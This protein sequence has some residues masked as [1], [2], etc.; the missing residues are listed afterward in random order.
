M[1][2]PRLRKV[3][4]SDLSDPGCMSIVMAMI[5]ASLYHDIADHALAA[6]LATGKLEAF[7]IID[8]EGR[9]AGL[10]SAQQGYVNETKVFYIA[11][12]TMANMSLE[13]WKNLR[14]S[15]QFFARQRG[16]AEIAFDTT[17]DN[18]RMM[19]IGR[20]LADEECVGFIKDTDKAVYFKGGV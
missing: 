10:I 19:E 9:Q 13:G 17:P 16:C 6:M 11:T 14:S 3:T 8:D 15:L 2:N 1:D 7:W 20:M 12:A 5:R 4:A 18:H